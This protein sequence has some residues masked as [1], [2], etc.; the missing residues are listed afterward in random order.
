MW[1]KKNWSSED[2]HECRDRIDINRNRITKSCD[3]DYEEKNNENA[4]SA[5][6]KSCYRQKISDNDD[7]KNKNMAH[8]N[9]CEALNDD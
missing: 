2:V 1:R 8:V 7:S 4:H 9:K 6:R 5:H 3:D